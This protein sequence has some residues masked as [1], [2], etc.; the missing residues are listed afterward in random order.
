MKK[1]QVLKYEVEL[2]KI[3]SLKLKLIYWTGEK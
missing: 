2:D 1:Y 3:G